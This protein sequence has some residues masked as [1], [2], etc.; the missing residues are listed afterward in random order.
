MIRVRQVKVGIDEEDKLI[1][2]ISLKLG[3]S[4]NKIKS[5]NIIKKSL[6]ARRKEY[7]HYVYEVDCD[8][9]DEEK[10]KVMIYF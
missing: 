7:I 5:F 10:I 6:D 9:E 2:K 4:S 1:K 8:I 3:I